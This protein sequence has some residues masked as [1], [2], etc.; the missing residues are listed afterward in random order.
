MRK[1]D[2]K[3]EQGKDGHQEMMLGKLV[4]HMRKIKIGF[5]P[6]IRISSTSVKEVKGNA[7]L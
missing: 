1:S 2:I 7:K 6:C 4:I 3:H 5:T